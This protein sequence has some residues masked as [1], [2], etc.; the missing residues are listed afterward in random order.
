MK[1]KL[2]LILLTFSMLLPLFSGIALPVSAAGNVA[3]IERTGAEYATLEA[4]VS[5]AT[6]GDTVTLLDNSS[7][8]ST[9]ALNK[10]LTINGAGKTVTYTGSSFAFT[11]SANVT[12]K[13][14]TVA[15]ANGG[16]FDV[17]SGSLALGV[18]NDADSAVTVNASG[19]TDATMPIRTSGSGKPVVNLYYANLTGNKGLIRLN[20]NQYEFNIYA[21]K[22]HMTCTDSSVTGDCRLLQG[23]ETVLTNPVRDVNIYGG[24]FN[25]HQGYVFLLKAPDM[26]VN[27]YNGYFNHTGSSIRYMLV[28]SNTELNIFGGFF[29]LPNLG[30][31]IDADMENGKITAYGGTVVCEG[32]I[33]GDT[34]NAT[35]PI[36][37]GSEATVKPRVYGFT[38]IHRESL[39]DIED[40][41]H[42]PYMRPALNQGAAV[43]LDPDVPGIRFS[44]TMP[45]Y[46]LRNVNIVK[47][48]GSEVSYGMLIAPLENLEGLPVLNFDTVNCL[49][50]V[51]GKD[52]TNITV[53]ET[54]IGP[55]G[56]VTFSAELTGIDERF[57]G[58]DY[59][60]N[61]YVKF[62]VDGHDVYVFSNYSEANTRNMKDI[63]TRALADHD[64]HNL[65][66]NAKQIEAL[67]NYA[68]TEY[69]EDDSF[70][71]TILCINVLATDSNNPDYNYYEG[72]T[73]ENYSFASRLEYI[74][75]VM[76]YSDPDVM[77]FQ[78]WSKANGWATVVTLNGQDG[79]YTSPQFPG[80]EWV[81]HMNRS[82]VAYEDY[83]GS[84]WW[85]MYNF[86]VYDT[87]KYE[88]ISSGTRFISKSGK[89]YAQP[90]DLKRN[91]ENGQTEYD[92]DLGELTWV[93]LQEKTTGLKVIY[94]STHPSQGTIRN[95]TG[96]ARNAYM[97]ENMQV[98][99]RQLQTVSLANDNAP[100][101]IGGDFNM[102]TYGGDLL[103]QYYQFTQVGHYEDAK[104]TGS[105]S[106]TCRNLGW[107]DNR[108]YWGS[109]D[110]S[111]R[112]DYIFASGAS[113]YGYEVLKGQVLPNGTYDPYAEVGSTYPG[114]EFASKTAEG[115]DISDH[116]P[117]VT[118][119]IVRKG[120]TYEAY[121]D[122]NDV[123]YNPN[124]KND[125]VVENATGTG[126]T[127]TKVLLNNEA[128]RAAVKTLASQ[129]G[130]Q[131]MKADI[132]ND[133]E[134]G[135]VLRISATD[136]TNLVNIAFKYSDL[137]TQA[138]SGYTKIKVTYKTEFTYAD[139][140]VSMRASK[141]NSLTGFVASKEMTGENNG[142]WQTAE[143]TLTNTSGNLKMLGFF[144]NYMET[145]LLK[146]DAIYIASIELTN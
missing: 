126:S 97:L 144:G 92:G 56:D 140:K 49:G 128:A 10:N 32:I 116:L 24:E 73:Y 121:D 33:Q 53:S 100:I 27:V 7:F 122:E 18:L 28:R 101:I 72:Q 108:P 30:V 60:A 136:E 79:R 84:D 3:K 15:A 82:G 62:K 34:N 47:D 25:S 59:T 95:A 89:M 64:E 14:M 88:Y 103:P 139:A 23:G 76:R 57:F 104:I 87:E 112:I 21:G 71:S 11:V 41:Y 20:S 127:P 117:I 46:A 68:D 107:F 123:Y 130:A 77:L 69:V 50:L 31:I 78:E 134:M 102:P 1:K 67:E 26:V 86:V 81:S 74:K 52:Y 51:E 118:N 91:R 17:T 6:A 142:E 55:Y 96:N 44:A 61:A 138:L 98:I 132:V 113:T 58:M 115:Y 125:Q 19:N 124:T 35:M 137:Y 48:T 135:N 114:G 4:A 13:N 12:V 40:V 9:V 2:L 29:N 22:Y 65:G 131:Y 42:R 141:G 120:V 133:S 106:G 85:E 119:V 70:V 37:Q 45:Q 8:A 145:G 93:V 94:A 39:S 83:N 63:A 110:N 5:A 105:D 66:Y 16:G 111:I 99:T 143:M 146:G 90:E 109:S 38:S 43:S 129:Y 36:S 75:E 80:Y 54:G